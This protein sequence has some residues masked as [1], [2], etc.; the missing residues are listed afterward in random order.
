MNAAERVQRTGQ[1]VRTNKSAGGFQKPLLSMAETAEYLS[2]GRQSVYD[3]AAQGKLPVVRPTRG[4]RT[5]KVVRSIL[6]EIVARGTLGETLP[7]R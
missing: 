7:S 5:M 1:K 2:V 6:E 3:M 4:K